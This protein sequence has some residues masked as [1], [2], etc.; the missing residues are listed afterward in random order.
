M[1][2]R[3]RQLIILR[4]SCQPQQTAGIDFL[5]LSEEKDWFGFCCLSD[6]HVLSLAWAAQ[7]RPGDV[8]VM[9]SDGLWDNLST[10][11]IL[12]EVSV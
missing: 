2:M 6:K 5:P 1:L 11:Q 4:H 9:G 10:K 7:V 8:L 3:M 12:D